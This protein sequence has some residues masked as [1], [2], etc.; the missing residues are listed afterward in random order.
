MQGLSDW[1]KVNALGKLL[2]NVTSFLLCFALA[3][4][5]RIKQQH[6]KTYFQTEADKAVPLKL[7]GIKIHEEYNVCYI[8]RIVLVGLC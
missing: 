3:S 6:T 5:S 1:E 4:M 2:C 8:L 7:V